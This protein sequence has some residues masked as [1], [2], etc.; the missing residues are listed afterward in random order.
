MG[1][2]CL[3][4]VISYHQSDMAASNWGQLVIIENKAPV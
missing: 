1:V 2:D 3:D 4:T